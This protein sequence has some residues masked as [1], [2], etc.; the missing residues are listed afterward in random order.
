[1]KE[2]CPLR[3]LADLTPE[4]RAEAMVHCPDIR[5]ALI[6]VAEVEIASGRV[7]PFRPKPRPKSDDPGKSKPPLGVA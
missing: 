1:M 3:T 7:A 4:K 5:A 2:S 6:P